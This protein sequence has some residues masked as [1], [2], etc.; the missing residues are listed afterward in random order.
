MWGSGLSGLRLAMT[1]ASGGH[2]EGMGFCLPA[3]PASMTRLAVCTQQNGAWKGLGCGLPNKPVHM[4][5]SPGTP[6]KATQ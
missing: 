4:G 3:G 2:P 1:Q 6:C 5:C